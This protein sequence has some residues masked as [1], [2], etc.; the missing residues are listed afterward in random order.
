MAYVLSKLGYERP[1]QHITDLAD[2][3][4]AFGKACCMPAWLALSH[5]AT[6][7]AV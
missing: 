4:L 1:W 5:H 3:V 6:Y 2:L 7:L